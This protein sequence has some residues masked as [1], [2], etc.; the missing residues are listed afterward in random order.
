MNAWPH[1]SKTGRAFPDVPW[2][3]LVAT[4]GE[5]F[6]VVQW[7]RVLFLH[8]G[9]EPAIVRAHLPFPFAL[10]LCDS[11]AIVSLVALTIRHFRSAP[12]A[13]FWTK[14]VPLI[15]EQR[16]FN[17]RTYIRYRGEPGAFFFWSWLSRIRGLPLPDAP[18]GLTCAFAKSRYEHEEESGDLRGVVEKASQGR[19]AY[20][21]RL[22]PGVAFRP[23][24]PG[25]VAEFTLERYTGYFWRG[26]GGRAFRACHPP[27]LQA[28][29]EVQIKDDSLVTAAFPWFRAARFLHAHYAPGFAGVRIGR[30][31]PLD[32]AMRA[33]RRH[34]HGASAFFEM[35]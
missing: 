23:C 9:L 13:P 26:G 1:E 11:K 35:P 4:K 20:E 10:E 34:H 6:L 18:L 16:L 22:D 17:V 30:P 12:S 15:G 33:S 14:V 27:W 19:F 29:V 7:H 8:F 3:G 21:A 32:V 2:C 24:A 5:P 28:A 25:S 31:R